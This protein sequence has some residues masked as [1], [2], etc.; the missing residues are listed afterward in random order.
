LYG[1]NVNIGSTTLIFQEQI[2]HKIS[3]F[4]NRRKD[5]ENLSSKLES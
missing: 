1:N 5:H 3:H 2:Y 4:M